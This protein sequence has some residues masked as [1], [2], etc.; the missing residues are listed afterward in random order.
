MSNICDAKILKDA[1]AHPVK[2]VIKNYRCFPDSAPIELNLRDGF[3]AFVGVNNS[4]KSSLLKFFYEF[5]NLF[6]NLCQAQNWPQAARQI[7][8]GGFPST[9]DLQEVCCNQNTRGIEVS[10]VLDENEAASYS[11]QP[12]PRKVILTIPRGTAICTLKMILPPDSMQFQIGPENVRASGSLLVHTSDG[13]RVANLA[14]LLRVFEDLTSTHYIPAFRNALNIGTNA[15]YFDIQTGQAFIA[16]WQ[17]IKT[18]NVKEQ[19]QNLYRITDVIRKIF[20]FKQLDI[21]AAADNSMFQIYVDGHPYKI[22]ELGAGLAQFLVSLLDVAIKKPS[23][24]LI[25]EPEAGLH[26][27]LQLEFL[28]ALGSFAGRG[29]IFSTHSL[30]LARSA[31]DWIYSVVREP[32]GL[33]KVHPFDSTPRLSELLGELSFSGYQELGCNKLLLVEGPKD[34]KTVQ[35]FLRFLDKDASV[36]L[37]PLGGSSLINATAY[38]QLEELKRLT[39]K[40]TVLIDSERASEHEPLSKDRQEFVNACTQAGILCHVLQRR[41]IEN[42][43]TDSAIKKVKSEKYRALTPYER[44]REIEPAWSK[45]E[46]WRIAREMKIGELDGTDLGE[47]LKSL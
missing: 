22:Q 17:S 37:I 43:L 1:G 25:D 7:A 31:A 42:Y 35:T 5:R 45:E 36:V 8:F 38:Q 20:G 14:P 39:N 27:S 32:T 3:V 10:L 18:G 46:N 33:S 29:V 6:A 40:I 28:T 13:G 24:V 9:F 19:S 41:A 4:G 16:K 11:P 44:L 34:V 30:G 47:F 12:V 26:P 23:Y 15:N 21:N 2:I